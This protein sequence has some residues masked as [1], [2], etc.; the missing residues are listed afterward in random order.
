MREWAT[1]LEV[2]IISVDYSLAP[3]APFPRAIEEVFYA[4]CWV[5]NNL[6]LVGS[7]GAK[8][9]FVGDSAGGNISTACIIK[10]IEMGIPLPQG[11]FNA[12]SIFLVNM[13][14]TPARIMGMFDSFLPFG[15]VMKIFKSYAQGKAISNDSLP[16]EP[17]K[18]FDNSKKF[19]K[20]EIPKA[21]DDEF[22]FEIPRNYLLAPYWAPDDILKE[23][24]PTKM[25]SMVTDPC[26][27][28][29]VEFGKKLKRLNVDTQI[30][31]LGGLFHGFLSFTQVSFDK[32]HCRNI[33]F[34]NFL[35][36]EGMPRRFA[37]LHATYCRTFR[38]EH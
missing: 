3:E 24:P 6:S 31:I 7:T 10:M 15:L 8:I 11:S 28:D 19:H 35:A 16:S 32:R 13:V 34:V 12:Y 1:K 27:D 22:V 18:G 25:V 30:E 23:F 17:S 14:K 36:L 21:P 29:C 37:S 38:V 5:L 26:L 9:V 20:S 4:Y 2:P 33:K